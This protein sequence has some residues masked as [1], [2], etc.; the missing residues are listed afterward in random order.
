MT[1]RMTLCA[2]LVCICSGLLGCCYVR[3]ASLTTAAMRTL[4]VYAS[5]KLILYDW[6]QILIIYFS[7]VTF[8]AKG[9][10]VS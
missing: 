2:Y 6:L 5:M 1:F 9:S 8:V 4:S 10:Y 7:S 3:A